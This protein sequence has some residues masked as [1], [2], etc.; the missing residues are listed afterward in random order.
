MELVHAFLDL[1]R[2]LDGL[3]ATAGYVGI[4]AIIFIE[5]GLLFPF[6]P[7]DSLLVTAGLVAVTGTLNVWTLGLL[8]SVAAIVG[9]QIQASPPMML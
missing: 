5:T 3:V 8:C 2:D 6:L 9:D 7:G 4:T 1:F